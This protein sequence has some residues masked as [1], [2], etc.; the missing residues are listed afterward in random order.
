M[1][2][3][4]Y[5]ARNLS[6]VFKGAPCV[7]FGAIWTQDKVNINTFGMNSNQRGRGLRVLAL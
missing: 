3:S 7:E 4:N 5:V 2:S 1:F 6:Q